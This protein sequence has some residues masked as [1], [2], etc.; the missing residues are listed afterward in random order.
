MKKLWK[1][2]ATVLMFV[3]A[4]VAGMT[5]NKLLGAEKAAPTDAVQNAGN[6]LTIEETTSN[7]IK[8]MAA[9]GSSYVSGL[10]ESVPYGAM[11]VTATVTPATA[12]NQ[13]LTW[14][15]AW[16]GTTSSWSSGKTVSEYLDYTT[17]GTN[18][19]EIYVW[20]A[21]PFGDEIVVTA[22]SSDGTN[23]T[24]TMTV[25]FAK[26]IT[27]VTALEGLG[28]TYDISNEEVTFD[29]GEM[30]YYAPDADNFKATFIYGVGTKTLTYECV[31]Y[32]VEFIQD[33]GEAVDETL[34]IEGVGQWS[35]TE[36]G[37]WELA[38]NY[39][40]LDTLQTLDETTVYNACA[41]ALRDLDGSHC[42]TLY[43]NFESTEA[44]SLGNKQ[45]YLI[46]FLMYY[47]EDSLG[48]LVENVSLSDSTLTI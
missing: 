18:A 3:T 40:P 42:G 17:V 14:S 23:K 26:R 27:G 29:F 13:K 21:A 12:A 11:K 2:L 41:Q 39:I 32:G 16:A 31:S 7:G 48:L 30:G 24:A 33:Y 44:D 38:Y 28:G 45:E 25:G 36:G 22:K 6:S 8:M 15:V 35:N 9:D 5:T 34:N 20:A 37:Y 19:H 1:G 10:G 4:F 47:S 43:L 46:R